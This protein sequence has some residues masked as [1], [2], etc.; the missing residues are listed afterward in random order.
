M[1]YIELKQNRFNRVVDSSYRELYELRRFPLQERL[2]VHSV[3]GE[4]ELDMLAVKYYGANNEP[5]WYK[6]ADANRAVLI[7]YKGS[8]KAQNTIEIPVN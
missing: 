5:S 3:I 6:I 4:Q 1:R 7:A 2:R 8:I